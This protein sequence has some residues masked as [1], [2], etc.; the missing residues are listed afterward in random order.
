MTLIELMIAVTISA[1]AI[2]AALLMVQQQQRSFQGG[3]KG[4]QAQ[5][6]ARSALLFLEQKIPLAGYGLDPAVALDFQWYGCAGAPS[7]CPRDRTDAPDELIFYA[8]NP[9]YRVVDGGTTA[10]TTYHGRAWEGIKVGSTDLSLEARA[11]EIFRRGQ[12]YQVT[13]DQELRYTYVTA[14]STVTAPA[15]GPFDVPI[16]PVAPGT[17]SPGTAANPFRR[18][19]AADPANADFKKWNG[20]FASNPRVF[21]IDRY[22]FYV[23]PVN[24]GGGRTDPFLALDQG[25]DRD[26]D[27]DIDLDDE[28]LIAEGIENF[29]VAYVFADPAIP[30]AGMDP[31]NAIQVP[32]PGGAATTTVDQ[33]TPTNFPGSYDATKLFPFLH[34]SQF[35]VRSSQPLEPP[36]KTNDQG[37]IRAIKI[38]LVARAAE[39]DATGTSNLRYQPS[40]RLWIMNFNTLP[41]W[42]S[43]YLAAHDGEDR[44]QRAVANTSLELPN[45]SS[46]GLLPN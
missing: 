22:R 16:E 28:L 39:P 18:Q 27:D 37:N 36:R 21:Q 14:R 19:D 41:A 35:F 3:L 31:G 2:G 29:Q 7:S 33:I 10:P 9:A 30:V 4:R 44:Y 20:C 26:A 25:V 13:C 40:S 5:G 6:A 15:D 34:S 8:R 24:L 42:I 1:M 12:I 11:G 43:S 46:R 45:L 17:L 38:A 32:A 23:R